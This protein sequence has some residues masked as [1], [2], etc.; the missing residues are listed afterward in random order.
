[1]R[2]GS[3]SR[4]VLV[5]LGSITTRRLRTALELFRDGEALMRQN[6]RRRH[7]DASAEEI[8]RALVAWVRT[9]PGAD[10]GDCPGTPTSLDP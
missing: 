8:E 7:P 1:M 2:E 4:I 10:H 3:A 9:R 6:L 5:T